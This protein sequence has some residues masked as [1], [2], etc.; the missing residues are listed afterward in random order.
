MVAAPIEL[1]A[2]AYGPDSSP[3]E[4]EAIRARVV[5]HERGD[6]VLWRE[7]PI[8]SEFSVDVCSDKVEQLC[9]AHR[10]RF[11]IIDSSAGARPSPAVRRRIRERQKQLTGQIERIFVVISP[12]P[13]VKA[14]SR[15]V[16][17]VSALN[18]TL[19]GSLEEVEEELRRVR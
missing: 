18:L 12:N 4:V 19:H 1:E 15:F 16:Q 2:R 6:A 14:M 11:L 3:E 5:L 10:C 7:L 13:L 17:A 8:I 9:A